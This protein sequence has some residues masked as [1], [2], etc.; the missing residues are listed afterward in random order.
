[1]HFHG[2]VTECEAFF[3]IQ[4]IGEYI[5]AGIPASIEKY[6][7]ST[8]PVD[9]TLPENNMCFFENDSFLCLLLQV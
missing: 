8:V 9:F 7:I 3:N 5:T 6:I 4:D 1:M 2:Q